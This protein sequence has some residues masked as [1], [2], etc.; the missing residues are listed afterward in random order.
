MSYTYVGD[1]VAHFV[2]FFILGDI[3]QAQ[4][5]GRS[6]KYGSKHSRSDVRSLTISF[7]LPDWCQWR[8]FKMYWSENFW[9]DHHLCKYSVVGIEYESK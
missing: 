5:L 3:L 2:S 4:E 7:S 8:E 1:F 6:K 9:K